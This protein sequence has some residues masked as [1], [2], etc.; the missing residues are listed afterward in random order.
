[1]LHYNSL[2]TD[3]ST[4]CMYM[5]FFSTHMQSC[6]RACAC[7]LAYLYV[8]MCV[9]ARVCKYMRAQVRAHACAYVCAFAVVI[10]LLCPCVVSPE[11]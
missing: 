7:T 4:A 1:M 10:V 5:V 2:A 3:L 8:C 6:E 9:R 11:S